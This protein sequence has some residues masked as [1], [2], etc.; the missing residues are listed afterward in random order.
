MKRADK[1]IF[2]AQMKDRLQK[3]KAVFLVDYQGLNVDAMNKVRRELKKID[4]EFFVVKNR[5]LKLACQDTDSESIKELFAGPCA[6]AITYEDVI[7]PAK[8]L[9]GLSKNYSKLD[10]KAGQM[11]GKPMETNAIKRLAELPGRDELLSQVLASMQ[12]VPSSLV[13]A[14]NGVLVN[15]LNVI[16][17]IETKKK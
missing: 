15:L 3:A 10:V 6:L 8:V 2:V 17:A 16:K 9:V 14:L 4:S 1:E 7:A 12:A 13:R 11:S 5:L